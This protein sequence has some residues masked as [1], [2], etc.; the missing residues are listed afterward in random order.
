ML[1][2]HSAKY[3]IRCTNR[4]VEIH[5][6]LLRSHGGNLLDHYY[7]MYHLMHLC[8]DC[9]HAAQGTE[10]YEG[11]LIISGLVTI[12]VVRD[13]P[14]YQGP[15]PYLSERYPYGLGQSSEAGSTGHATA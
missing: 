9:H 15:D 14:M 2:E 1:M 5:H 4:A 10:A 12:D 11:G 8:T 13:W 6:R 3:R 7:E